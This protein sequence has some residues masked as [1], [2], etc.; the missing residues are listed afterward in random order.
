VRLAGAVMQAS[1]SLLGGAP[2][3][4]SPIS[5][6]QHIAFVFADIGIANCL[7]A[8]MT[9][10]D[11]SI[12][13]KS[14]VMQEANGTTKTS[15]DAEARL[16]GSELFVDGGRWRFK[17]K[18]MTAMAVAGDVISIQFD[19][20]DKK[21][22]ELSASSQN[23][24][25]AYGNFV[26]R[27]TA[28]YNKISN[29]EKRA[30]FGRIGSSKGRS[31]AQS[32][33]MPWN[34]ED[35]E[36]RKKNVKR[37]LVEE[38]Y[39]TEPIPKRSSPLRVPT[40]E[41]LV[42][43]TNSKDDGEQDE[44]LDFDSTPPIFDK[45]ASM[46]D[47]RP[48]EEDDLP[49]KK[50][51]KKRRIID[52]DD[53]DDNYAEEEPFTETNAL[54][55]TPAAAATNVVSPWPTAVTTVDHFDHGDDEEHT[56]SEEENSVAT[57]LKNQPRISQFFAS[58]NKSLTPPKS[59]QPTPDVLTPVLSPRNN[60][61]ERPPPSARKDIFSF[62]S[63]G[64]YGSSQ[65]SINMGN[66]TQ[67]KRISMMDSKPAWLLSNS[68]SERAQ[69]SAEKRRG[70]LFL[71]SS[72]LELPSDPVE[73]DGDANDIVKPPSIT[74]EWP[75][76]ADRR[77]QNGKSGKTFLTTPKDYHRNSSIWGAPSNIPDP[78]DELPRYRG[79]RNLGNTCYMNSS[80]QMLYSCRAFMTA[81][82]QSP[83][84]ELVQSVCDIYREL[85]RSDLTTTAAQPDQIKRAI[86]KKTDKFLGYEQRDAH[87]F[88]ADLIDHLDEEIKDSR[89]S[90][91]GGET[92]ATDTVVPTDDFCLTVRAHLQCTSCGY[93]R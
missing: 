24:T 89:S 40:K 16:E 77:R 57:S 90:S 63:S 44:M 76:Y 83:G 2:W 62:A 29:N 87:E 68:L 43:E 36:P 42:D 88:L 46:T 86:D 82:Q 38:Q 30:G 66:T 56:S 8:I 58:A 71:S 48:E 53:D 12:L 60:T 25:K 51:I 32:H 93:R 6:K 7:I 17:L 52:D 10:K 45:D 81:L 1:D 50:V 72:Q 26:K 47:E 54:L 33:R 4:H 80:L 18:E 79:L 19:N 69:S 39:G 75:Q 21:S 23:E 55:T 91:D 27:L 92:T 34:D 73:D 64:K 28:H 35:E 22:I 20:K 41:S 11:L 61:P 37:T 85:Q 15:W 84:G 74:G 3:F 31:K 9:K 78:A 14:A 67:R 59:K 13:Y 49:L 70:G 5:N 65:R